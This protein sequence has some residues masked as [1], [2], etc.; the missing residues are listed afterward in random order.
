V[1]ARLID[2]ETDSR[3]TGPTRSAAERQPRSGGRVHSGQAPAVARSIAAG[4]LNLLVHAPNAVREELEA[5]RRRLLSAG[6]LDAARFGRLEVLSFDALN[7][8]FAVPSSLRD[9]LANRLGP[10]GVTA[11][12]NW[13]QPGSSCATVGSGFSRAM[14]LGVWRPAEGRALV[15]RETEV[16]SHEEPGEAARRRVLVLKFSRDSPKL[17]EALLRSAPARA[18]AERGVETQPNW[19]HGAKVFV[20]G[21]GP[22][23]LDAPSLMSGGRLLPSH[24]VIYEEDEAALMAALRHLAYRVKK[25]KPGTAGRCPLPDDEAPAED[26]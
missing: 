25:L 16:A 18:A 23:A 15:C 26:V 13:G 3:E 21:F 20:E 1:F 19:A 4:R 7:L 24:V 22:E 10:P 11:L 12:A 9:P 6:R 8:E 5:S 17:D 14:A 2:D